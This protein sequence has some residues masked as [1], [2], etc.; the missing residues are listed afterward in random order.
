MATMTDLW[1]YRDGVW[2]LT[3]A[4]FITVRLMLFDCGDRLWA[5]CCGGKPVEHISPSTSASVVMHRAWDYYDA[6]IDLVSDKL[7]DM[8]MQTQRR[9]A[10]V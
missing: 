1:I 4:P 7:V 3:V 6:R 2:I 8:Q 10:Y 5:A 9:T